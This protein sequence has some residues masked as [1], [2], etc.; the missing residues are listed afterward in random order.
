MGEARA[1]VD[2]FYAAYNSGYT[3][4][5]LPQFDPDV[6]TVDPAAGEMRGIDAFAGYLAG[7]NRGFPDAKL[8]LGRAVES[9]ELVAIEGTYTG[10]NTGPLAGPQGEIPATGRAIVLPYMEIYEVRGGRIARHSIYYDQMSFLG[11]LG[12]L[13]PPA[14]AGG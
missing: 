14:A 7:F 4:D 9:G 1:V 10:T 11:Q 2:R 8:N 6:V 3:S 12:L 5:A 13:P